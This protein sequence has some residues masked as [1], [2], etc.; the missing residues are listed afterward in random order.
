MWLLAEM[1]SNEKWKMS[2][3]NAIYRRIKEKGLIWTALDIFRRQIR[4]RVM[5]RC[6]ICIKKRK[7]LTG[8][9]TITLDLPL[10]LLTK[11]GDFGT[12][13][14]GHKVVT[15]GHLMQKDTRGLIQIAGKPA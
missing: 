11:I 12:I 3:L 8:N 14:I 2:K 9:G 15:S 13:M 7:F 6:V 10:S 1:A 5:D 4:I